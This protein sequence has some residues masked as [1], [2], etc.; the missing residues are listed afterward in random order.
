MVARV[1][2]RLRK[3]REI[4]GLDASHERVDAARASIELHYHHISLPFAGQR[5]EVH[6]DVVGGL[7]E[8]VDRFAINR[9]MPN[10][11]EGD[12]VVIHDTGAHGHSMG[13][14]YNGRLRPAELLLT[15]AGEVLEIRRPERFEDYVATVR[16]EPRRVAMRTT[17]AAETGGADS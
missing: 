14:T 17:V 12:L 16:F 5:P 6:V 2:N 10:P 4:A 13:F 9:P 3:E 8:N 11:A 1:I 15:E 7:C